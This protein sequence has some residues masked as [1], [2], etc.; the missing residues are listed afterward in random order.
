MASTPSILR[1][2]FLLAA[3]ALLST[4]APFNQ[5]EPPVPV[6]PPPIINGTIPEKDEF[7]KAPLGFEKAAAGSILRYR[8]VPGSLTID[9]NVTVNVQSAWQLQYR[10]QNSVGN[11]EASI[12]T[13]IVPHNPRSE[14]LF[15]YSYYTVCTLRPPVGRNH[16][17][18]LCSN[19]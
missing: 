11:P 9:N 19:L 14:N 1:P 16:F 12:V 5:N 17:T 10:T 4:A 13:V 3:L 2:L 6:W 7:Y 8:R 18:N 15:M